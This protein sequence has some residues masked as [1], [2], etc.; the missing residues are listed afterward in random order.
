MSDPYYDM[1]RLPHHVS[2]THP[3]MSMQN[4]AAQ[5]SPFAALAGYD[6]LLRETARLTERRIEPDEAVQAELD[7]RL[8]LLLECLPLRPEI[9]VTYFQPDGKKVGGSYKTVT[10]TVRKFQ[11]SPCALLMDCGTS[12]PFEHILTLEGACFS[13]LE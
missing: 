10:G 12:I 3:Q 7:Q 13:V 9:S 6:A 11:R 4:R 1:L 2:K 5:F 8:R